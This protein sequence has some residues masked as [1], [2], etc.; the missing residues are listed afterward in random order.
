M[1][2]TVEA[3]GLWFIHHGSGQARRALDAPDRAQIDHLL[4]K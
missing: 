2:V 3:G 1:N 4:W